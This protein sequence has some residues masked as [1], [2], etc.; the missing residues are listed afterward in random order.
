MMWLLVTPVILVV[1]I[2]VASYLSWMNAG[3]VA[4][5]I[6]KKSDEFAHSYKFYL[7]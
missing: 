4:T 3:G 1:A 5:Y 6:N 2:V 7:H